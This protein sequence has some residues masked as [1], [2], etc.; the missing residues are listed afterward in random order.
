MASVIRGNDNFDSSEVGASTTFGAV[1]TYVFGMV[2]AQT[3]LQNTTHAGSA[4]WLGGLAGGDTDADYFSG[5]VNITWGPATSVLS[6]TWR[7]MS[8]AQDYE[9]RSFG[10][11]VRIS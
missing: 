10:L 1:G 7:T 8:R 3:N 4:L 6:G 9:T 2:K 5:T 11:F